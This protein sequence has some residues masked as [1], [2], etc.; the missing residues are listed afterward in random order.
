MSS[1]TVEDRLN[2]QELASIYA[3]AMDTND[4]DTWIRL[5]SPTGVWE[6][7]RGVYTGTEELLRLIPDLGARVQGKRHV[8]TNHIIKGNDN[9]ATMI[10][11]MLVV[12]AKAG[13]NSVTTATYQDVLVKTDG[14]W[15]FSKRVMRI[16]GM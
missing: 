16:D 6:G 11:Y 3:Y 13:G 1:L 4:L 14:V 12:D 9:I 8:I 7:P 15:L 5:W 10:C 2:I